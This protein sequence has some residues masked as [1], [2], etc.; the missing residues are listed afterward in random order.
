MKA[1]LRL[2]ENSTTLTMLGGVFLVEQD[3][4]EILHDANLRGT[5][6]LKIN[7]QQVVSV[8][9]ECTLSIEKVNANGAAKVTV[10]GVCH[11]YSDASLGYSKPVIMDLTSQ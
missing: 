4:L 10:A 5:L 8:P 9:Q 6:L 11:L 3:E 1:K 7:S 2:T